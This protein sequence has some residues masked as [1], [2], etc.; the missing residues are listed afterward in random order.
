MR[1]KELIEQIVAEG[2]AIVSSGDCSEMEISNAQATGRF[3]VREDGMGFVRRTKEWL[4]LQLA[5][6][7][8]HPNFDGRYNA[9]TER[10]K[11]G[12][13]LIAA[14]R[15]RQ[16]TAEDRTPKHDDEHRLGE[17][18]QAAACYADIAGALMHGA[19][20]EDIRGY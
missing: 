17:L 20:V 8:A 9:D 1:P 12:I 4:A 10:V 18:S 14:E 7:K 2:G 13:E 16:I 5:R 3:A 19:S 15:E 6:E 11:T